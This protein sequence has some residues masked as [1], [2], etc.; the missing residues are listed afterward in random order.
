MWSLNVEDTVPALAARSALLVITSRQIGIATHAD[1]RIWDDGGYFNAARPLMR[2]DGQARTTSKASTQSSKDPRP[3]DG[4]KASGHRGGARIPRRVG[5]GGRPWP[6]TLA[7]SRPSRRKTPRSTSV[8]GRVGAPRNKS[9]AQPPA[10]H[11]RASLEA[12]RFAASVGC[13]ARQEH[14]PT[15]PFGIRDDCKEFDHWEPIRR[16]GTSDVA[17]RRRRKP[18]RRL[19]ERSANRR[20]SKDRMRQ[21]LLDLA[22]RPSDFPIA[23][24][25]SRSTPLRDIEGSVH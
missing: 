6:R 22:C 23:G 1:W 8:W 17:P 10:I 11:H 7:M 3:S 9:I 12:R 16:Q 2:F 4:T 20:N 24:V 15:V 18:D 25:G 19:S 13:T 5:S 14:S 21:V